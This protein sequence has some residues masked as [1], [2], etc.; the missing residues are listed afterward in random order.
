MMNQLLLI[1]VGSTGVGFL[2]GLAMLALYF[3]L[4]RTKRGTRR[5]QD[6]D[7]MMDHHY[8][9]R[10]L[11]PSETPEFIG[12]SYKELGLEKCTAIDGNVLINK[13]YLLNHVQFSDMIL[14]LDKGLSVRFYLTLNDI[15]PIK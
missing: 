11:L 15:K 7:R 2:I 4:T 12:A 9:T 10:E 1:D 6:L 3:T 13:T 14:F 5:Q 8:P